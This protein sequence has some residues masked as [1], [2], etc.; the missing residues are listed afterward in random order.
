MSEPEEESVGVPEW[1]V[2]YGDMMSLLLTFF[3]MLVSM[4]QLKEDDGRTRI[5]MDA[6]R[7][8]FGPSSGDR[9]APGRSL[10]T[11]STH[12]ERAS[13]SARAEGADERGGRTSPGAAGEHES[14]SQISPGTLVTLGGAAEFARFDAGLNDELKQTLD[15]VARVVGPTSNRIM[16]R[17]HATPEPLPNDVDFLAGAVG[18]TPAG[19]FRSSRRLLSIDGL[20]VRDQFDLSY[21]R[22]RAVADYL[23][24]RKIPRQRLIVTA[25]GDAE[26]RVVTRRR[27][28]QRRNR[29]VDVF[30]IDA[31]ITPPQ[32]AR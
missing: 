6:I 15:V 13:A 20:P 26:F 12:G 7:E 16:I 1:V 14:A 5:M 32:T 10:Q 29:R 27:D 11:H 4:S 24:A 25:A 22:A 8:V 21:A 2:T 18:G 23:A 28:V 30:L 17:G 19:G 31:Y 9:G 3:I